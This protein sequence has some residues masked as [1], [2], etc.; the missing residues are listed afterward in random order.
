LGFFLGKSLNSQGTLIFGF[1]GWANWEFAL[2][3]LEKPTFGERIGKEAL[4]TTKRVSPRRISLKA[5][6]KPKG[7]TKSTK[8][9]TTR[10]VG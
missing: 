5:L 4:I 10:Y 1:L 2:Y 6:T 3:A 9:N 7:K 8:K